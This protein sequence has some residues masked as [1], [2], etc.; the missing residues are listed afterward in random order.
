MVPWGKR[1]LEASEGA[2]K[3][4]AYDARIYFKIQMK[5]NLSTWL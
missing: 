5:D 2:S 4:K 1:Y 3:E